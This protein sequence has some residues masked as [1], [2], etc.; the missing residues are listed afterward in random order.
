MRLLDWLNRSPE[1]AQEPTA[2]APIATAT[3]R[4]KRRF[5]RLM[6]IFTI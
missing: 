4:A 2:D 1:S 5:V 3:T 6:Q